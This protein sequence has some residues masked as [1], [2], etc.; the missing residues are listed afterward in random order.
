MPIYDGKLSYLSKGKDLYNCILIFVVSSIKD[1]RST[2]FSRRLRA[3]FSQKE[4]YDLWNDD[5]KKKAVKYFFKQPKGPD[6][7]SRIDN[8][9]LMPSIDDDIGYSIRKDS[10]LPSRE[11]DTILKIIVFIKKY[12]GNSLISL[13][14]ADLKIEK[15]VFLLLSA[16]ND[17]RLGTREIEDIFFKSSQPRDE[18]FRLK[19]LEDIEIQK[20]Y[21]KILKP[22]MEHYLTIKS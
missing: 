19:N 11:M 15:A 21:N 17:K 20:N 12:Y 4:Y 3:V 6:F 5:I 10:K 8:T 2:M 13:E 14:K 18:K 22:F 7:L 16:L 1:S 9:I